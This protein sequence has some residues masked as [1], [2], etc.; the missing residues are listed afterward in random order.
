[1]SALKTKNPP[2]LFP[3]SGDFAAWTCQAGSLARCRSRAGNEFLVG[4]SIDF[5]KRKTQAVQYSD[6]DCLH[7]CCAEVTARPPGLTIVGGRKFE[8]VQPGLSNNRK[9]VTFGPNMQKAVRGRKRTVEM[10]GYLVGARQRICPTT[11]R[12]NSNQV[13]AAAPES[14]CYDH[15]GPV[16]DHFGALISPEIAQQDFACFGMME[17]RHTA[18]VNRIHTEGA[19]Q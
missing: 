17:K 18:F 5:V 4:N 11:Q 8:P 19:S 3:E 14:F 13:Y 12:D 6:P 7:L 2:H 10:N 16:L 15:D 9:H 1:M